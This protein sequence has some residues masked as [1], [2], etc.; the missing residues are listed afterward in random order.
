MYVHSIIPSASFISTNDECFQYS[1]QAINSLFCSSC[2]PT[3]TFGASICSSALSSPVLIPVIIP[4]TSRDRISCTFLV[5]GEMS[6]F[7]YL[8]RKERDILFPVR[9]LIKATCTESKLFL[10]HPSISQ[11]KHYLRYIINYTN[12]QVFM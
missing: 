7:L 2:G 10:K 6:C 5:N 12:A 11:S 4:Y 1:L 8:S 3:N 9:V